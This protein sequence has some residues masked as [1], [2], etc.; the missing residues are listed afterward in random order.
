MIPQMQQMVLFQMRIYK[1]RIK[2]LK[3]ILNHNI[4]L[5]LYEVKNIDLSNSHIIFFLTCDTRQR[6]TANHELL[7]K[8]SD[9]KSEPFKVPSSEQLSYVP[10]QHLLFSSLGEILVNY[11]LQF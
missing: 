6:K 2:E 5:E 8:A 1:S 4:T 7:K 9:P 3:I 10:V 11:T